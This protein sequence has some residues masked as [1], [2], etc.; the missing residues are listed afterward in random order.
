MKRQYKDK[1]ALK[2]N[3]KQES[4]ELFFAFLHEATKAKAKDTQLVTILARALHTDL[5]LSNDVETLQANDAIAFYTVVRANFVGSD[6]KTIPLS[7]YRDM[8]K[9]VF[10]L[11]GIKARIITVKPVHEKK[12]KQE[13]K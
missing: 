8:V 1:P 5:F 4:N 11:L 10:S 9:K 6:G 2:V 13:A 3:I 12:G 7:E